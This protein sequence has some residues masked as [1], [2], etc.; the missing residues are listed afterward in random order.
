MRKLTLLS[1]FIFV[2][3]LSMAQTYMSPDNGFQVQLT[4][5]GF[6]INSDSS[7]IFFPKFKVNEPFDQYLIVGYPNTFEMNI[8]NTLVSCNVRSAR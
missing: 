4:D 2:T 3:Q 8:A 6:S 7:V 5:M 1:V